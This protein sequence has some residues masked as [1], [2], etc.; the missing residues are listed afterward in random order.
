MYIDAI[1]PVVRQIA[2]V[3]QWKGWKRGK[4]IYLLL[5]LLQ[6]YFPINYYF[7]PNNDHYDERFSWRMF[8]QLSNEFIFVSLDKNGNESIALHEYLSPRWLPTVGKGQPFLLNALSF[9]FCEKLPNTEFINVNRGNDT[10]KINC[11][12]L[13]I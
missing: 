2:I 1:K 8:S 3:L 13:N 9:Y 5:L 11:I 6:L 12:Y 10:W 7:N 4:F